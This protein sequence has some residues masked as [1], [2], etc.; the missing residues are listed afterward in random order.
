M[1]ASTPASATAA[2]HRVVAALSRP[3]LAPKLQDMTIPR[4]GRGVDTQIR[5]PPRLLPT[6]TA[7]P[8]RPNEAL[9][10]L[11]QKRLNPRHPE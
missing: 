7:R 11:K 5:E 10:F 1:P 4:C 9:Y 8:R 3:I 6:L 2:N